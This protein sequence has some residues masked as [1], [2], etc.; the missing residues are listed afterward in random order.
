MTG[1]FPSKY[2]KFQIEDSGGSMRDIAVNS[3]NGVGIT[4]DQQ[5]LSA[6]QEV[7]KSFATGQGTVAMTISGPASNS[8]AVTASTTGLVAALSGSITVLNGV[9][10]GNTPLSFGAY[11]GTATYWTAASSDLVFGAIDCILVS[12][13]TVDPSTGMY[14]ANL[15]LAPSR[16]NDPAWGTTAIAASST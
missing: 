6:L 9:N 13:L 16:T 3:I 15:C 5:D 1:R 10:G 2:F 7:L 11:F 4:Y 14:S 12:G 8:T